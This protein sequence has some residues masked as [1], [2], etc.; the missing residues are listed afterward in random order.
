[1]GARIEAETDREVTSINLTCLKGD[2]S[3][4]V[5]LV[6]DVI[7]N[8]TIDGAEL[9]VA[10]QEQ[11]A[12]LEGFSKQ[13]FDTTIEACHYNAFRDHQM[14]QPIRG[15]ADNIQNITVEM[16]QEHRAANFTGE[17]IVVVGTGN[18]DHDAF[19]KLVDQGF[20]S[21]A[22]EAAQP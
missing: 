20:S 2:L 16:L 10:K 17:N 3:R 11:S 15:D 22:K 18:V 12:E 4:A 21:V 14:G 7:A 9:E 5:S 1:M 6:G 8:A 19:A 13:Q